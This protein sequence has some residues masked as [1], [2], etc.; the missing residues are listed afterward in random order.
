M[1]RVFGI[2]IG[3]A[4]ALA[5]SVPATASAAVKIRVGPSL[6]AV[7]S[8]GQFA[9]VAS[10][11]LS[12]K[13]GSLAFVDLPRNRVIGRVHVGHNPMAV[14]VDSRRRFAYVANYDVKGSVSVV[15][16]RR[17]VIARTLPAG[18]DP[19]NVQLAS[20][21]GRNLLLVE[22]QG[23][24]EPAKGSVDVWDLGTMRRIRRL[25]TGFNPIGLALLPGRGQALVGDGNRGFAW[26]LDL[27]QLR[28]VKRVP[29]PAGPVNDIEVG[30]QRVYVVSVG[31]I[32]V[33]R[34]STLAPL[35]QVVKPLK[36][37]DPL[38]VAVTPS[39]IGYVVDNGFGMP[40]AGT[41]QILA[42][43]RTAGRRTVGQNAIGIALA[44]HNTRL[45][46]T[47]YNEGTLW[48]IPTPKPSA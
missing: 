25:A 43:P 12:A 40:L 37:F 45:V 47:S 28:F 39:G 10:A 21:G 20:R 29:V 4:L 11:P 33:L 36:P 7:A 35:G 17:R 41:V 1:Q 31:G 48:V 24:T 38:T 13:A 42:G 16:L 34:Q 6:S 26:V 44:Q 9:Y 30:G 32:S 23:V 8:S 46:V 14:A 5:G 22:N 27:G 2:V 19:G 15:D 3:G 18:K